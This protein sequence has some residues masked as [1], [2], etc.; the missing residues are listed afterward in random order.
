MNGSHRRSTRGG[1]AV[2]VC[3][4]VCAGPEHSRDL[5]SYHTWEEEEVEE[6]EE[7]EEKRKFLWRIPPS[8]AATH[9]HN[10]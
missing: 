10:T 2:C 8:G 3:V 1:K 4:C 5:P 7:E 6:E 9:T